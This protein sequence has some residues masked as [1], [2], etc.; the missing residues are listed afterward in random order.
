M[1]RLIRQVRMLQGGRW[2]E[3]DLRISNGC[4]AEIGLDLASSPGEVEER[5]TGL[6]ALPAAVDLHVHFNE[7]GRTDWE[8]FATGTQAAAA[9]GI[10]YVADMPL[11]S[12][13]PTVNRE[14][15]RRKAEV[16]AR[17]SFVDYGF[18]GGLVP[19]NEDE[20]PWLIED[21][22]MGIK[23]FFSPSGVSEFENADLPTLR[24][25]MERMVGTGLR[26]AVHAEDPGVLRQC[27]RCLSGKETARDWL[28]SR[29]VEAE[30]AAVRSIGE[31]AGEVGCP[32]TIVHVSSPEVVD[33]VRALAA[34]GV[35]ILCETCPH[36]LLLNA[37]DASRLGPV[38]KCA[39]PL[40]PPA[41]MRALWDDLWAGAIE[42]VGSDHS[43]S[44]PEMKAGRSFFEAWGG[45]AG[46]QHGNLLLMEQVG[47]EDASKMAMLQAAFAERPAGRAGLEGKGYLKVGKDADFMLLEKLPE[48]VQVTEGDLLTRHR[49][50]PYLGAKLSFAVDSFWLRG[51]AV[52]R[53]GEP[54]GEPAGRWVKRGGSD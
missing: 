54:F 1:D 39:P 43:P 33:V 34:A 8:G 44:P 51:N 42:T 19:G 12:I 3:N 13:P 17:Q 28:R 45:I 48:P 32:L 9:G 7:P 35:D 31:I 15:L 24:R 23:A 29:P 50:S 4:F 16:V 36:Y 26:L 46:I 2:A 21:G 49:A 10:G 11:N 40:R 52:L 53:Q 27:A 30:M 20:L 41:V 37:N 47:L 14:A 18:W 38:A 5:A 25:G 6:Y 22:V